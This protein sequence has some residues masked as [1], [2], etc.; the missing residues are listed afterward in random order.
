MTSKAEALTCRPSLHIRD[1]QWTQ[2]SALLGRSSVSSMYCCQADMCCNSHAWWLGGNIQ[3]HW[4]G[5]CCSTTHE[6]GLGCC[7]CWT[8]ML[9]GPVA[10][11]DACECCLVIMR[12]VVE[13]Y[14]DS[15]CTSVVVVYAVCQAEFV[16]Q[17]RFIRMWSVGLLPQHSA[18][19]SD[20]LCCVYTSH[21]SVLY[22]QYTPVG[23][24]HAFC[25]YGDQG[26]KRTCKYVCWCLGCRWKRGCHVLMT[27]YTYQQRCTMWAIMHAHHL[28]GWSVVALCTVVGVNSRRR[29]PMA[30]CNAPSAYTGHK[31]CELR[32]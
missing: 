7:E 32:S 30:V 19:M 31:R 23:Y 25:A 18:G 12:V 26:M 8:C 14:V 4:K 6:Y 15:L 22:S 20:T 1:G 27:C 11:M 2:Q 3:A 21:P 9:L 16:N 24:T 10:Y 5:H 28:H 13:L 29:V 17:Q